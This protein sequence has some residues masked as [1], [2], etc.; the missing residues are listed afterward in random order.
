MQSFKSKLFQ[1]EN[2]MRDV[3]DILDEAQESMDMAI[4]YLDEALAHIRAGK[5]DIRLL[6]GIRVDSYG[7]MVPINNVAA[8]T[9]PDARS[10]AIKPWDKSMFR[11]IEK[12][13]IDSSL[14]IMP[15]NN[16][17]IIRIGIPPLTEERRKQL[18]KQ[19][20][21]EGE[22]AKVSV[23]NARRDAIDALKKSVKDGLAEDAQK[24]GEEK[25]QKIH[26]KFIKQIDDML[27]A[28]SK[29]KDGS[30]E[31]SDGLDTLQKNLADYARGMNELNSKSGD[32]GKGVETL[33]TSAESISKGIQTLDKA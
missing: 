8:V 24:G 21:G 20:K 23:R 4:M 9:T 30:K 27:A 29:L 26:D 17:E 16:G 6:D 19:C 18:A 25:L 14:G 22:T 11:V 33:N 2:N 15:E 31:L 28:S 5:A 32:L 3:K 12:A 7:S 13:I 10:I 1:N